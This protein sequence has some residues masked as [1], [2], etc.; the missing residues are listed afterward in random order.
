MNK[1]TLIAAGA[2]ALLSLAA[3]AASA[4]TPGRSCFQM[5][6]L[7]GT[8]ADGDQRIYARVGVKE[9]Y[10]IDL[11]HRCSSLLSQEG[12]VLTPTGGNNLICTPLDVDLRARDLGG[13]S[14]PCMIKSISRLTPEEAAALP[15]KVKP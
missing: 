12:I 2:V 1:M 4:A 10:R 5:T 6:Q 14:T 3:S 11:A 8:R 9:I 15:A 7:Q 13:S